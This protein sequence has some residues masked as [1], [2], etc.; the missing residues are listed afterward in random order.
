MTFLVIILTGA[1]ETVI[2][3]GHSVSIVVYACTAD[4]PYHKPLMI[5]DIAENL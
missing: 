3:D 5:T 4:D 1:R 2:G